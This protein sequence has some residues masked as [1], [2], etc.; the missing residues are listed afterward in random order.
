[1]P[2]Q[3]FHLRRRKAVDE[4]TNSFVAQ[5]SLRAAAFFLAASSCAIGFA[6]AGSVVRMGWNDLVQASDVAL[7]GR[8]LRTNARLCPGP[9]RGT[10]PMI[11]TLIEVEV[12]DALRGDLGPRFV[13]SV[14][15]GFVGSQ[16]AGVGM[17]IAGLRTPEP[18]EELLLF[19]SAP[20]EPGWRM[21]IGLAQGCRRI[22][23]DQRGQAWIENDWREIEVLETGRAAP[24]QAPQQEALHSALSNLRRA[25]ALREQQ[26][27]DASRTP[28]R[29]DGR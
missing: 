9:W 4:T 23:R 25:F 6:R 17:R 15:G 20:S 11:E 16:S 27:R 1:M 29:Q 24:L 12:V 26:E 10:R 28:N 18:G 21:P 7:H 19:L 2:Q 3:G 14:P 5:L 13:F 8:V 22:L